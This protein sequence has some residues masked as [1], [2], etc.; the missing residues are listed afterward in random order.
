MIIVPLIE[1]LFVILIVLTLVGIAVPLTTDYIH[2]ANVAQAIAEI[3]VLE[4]EIII[5]EMENECYPGGGCAERP[6]M[7]E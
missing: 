4:K 6:E 2:Q 7:L 5:F 1:I 3:R